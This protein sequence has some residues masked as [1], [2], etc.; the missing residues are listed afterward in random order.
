MSVEDSW[1]NI[2]ASYVNGQHGRSDNTSSH[3][4]RTTGN[5]PRP[6]RALPIPPEE[7]VT[8]PLK[9]LP[10]P[11][12][13]ALDQSSDSWSSIHS[14][15]A[16]APHVDD[17]SDS[18]DPELPGAF[19]GQGSSSSMPNSSHSAR[20]AQPE[21]SDDPFS[22]S[23]LVQRP[24]SPQSTGDSESTTDSIDH[25]SIASS[26]Q[27]PRKTQT[28]SRPRQFPI[29]SPRTPRGLPL[30]ARRAM[31]GDNTELRRRK[32]EGSHAQEETPRRT[33]RRPKQTNLAFQAVNCRSSFFWRASSIHICADCITFTI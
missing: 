4:G 6:R 9:P 22:P 7:N 23:G 5:V 11:P 24:S 1:Q 19:T 33:R 10:A 17:S 29:R 12:Q 31:L 25:D 8:T 14:S 30:S 32:R 21:D 13:Q 16:T 26:I 27:T 15:A 28:P 2:T 3:S 20:S 18:I